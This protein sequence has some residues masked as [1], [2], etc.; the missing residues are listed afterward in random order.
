[1]ASSILEQDDMLPNKMTRWD[2][3]EMSPRQAAAAK[4][5][6][7]D[8]PNQVPFAHRQTRPQKKVARRKRL[9]APERLDGTGTTL[10]AADEDEESCD[11]EIKSENTRARE[12]DE[13]KPNLSDLAETPMTL[14]QY[15]SPSRNLLRGTRGED[16]EEI[17][18]WYFACQLPEHDRE[19]FTS[20]QDNWVKDIWDMGRSS[21]PIR[22]V[23][24]AFA[25]HKKATL[26]GGRAKPE[27][28][29]QKGQ[30]IQDIVADIRQSPNGPDSATV[31]A[32]AALAYFDIRDDQLD[33]SGTHLR[34][35]RSFID[36]P[37]MSPQG[38]L[39]CVWIDL[40]QALFTTT[41]PNLPFYVPVAFRGVPKSLQSY[42]REAFRL[43]AINASQC[44]RSPVFTLDMASDLLG[45]LHALCYCSEII[46]PPETPPFGQVY[47]LEYGLRVVQA[48]AKHNDKDYLT[49]PIMLISSAIQLHV[50]MAAR[51]YT[52]QARETH[53][54]LINIACEV[55]NGF[56]DMITQWY[57]AA[58]LE[59]LIWVLFTLAAS[60]RAHERP[61]TTEMI[62]LLYKA[63]RKARINTCDDLET[64]LRQWPWL[65]NWHPV[66]IDTVW[67]I[68]CARYPDLVP[69]IARRDV[70]GTTQDPNKARHRWFLGGLEFYNS[71]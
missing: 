12:L 41:E 69:R 22:S 18:Q 63:L 10:W 51:F 52:P 55:T 4:L 54:G 53:L 8:E 65:A 42:Q 26:G 5:A 43:G 39:Y 58:G 48:R 46:A 38:W 17:G 14:A 16:V 67:E 29:E 31:V 40:R 50:W 56:D 23:L 68:L 35:V 34:A 33:A 28:Y 11:E 62:G 19:F 64:K 45:K 21:E 9:R 27:Y 6:L 71:L 36:M 57:I 32:M 66:Q 70:P 7:V 59:S 30:I 20:V 49:A 60:L 24:G 25:L 44:P 13:K 15:Q 3:H 61:Q 2:S 37:N 1:M 47:A